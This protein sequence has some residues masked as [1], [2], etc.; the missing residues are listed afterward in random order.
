[1]IFAA[2]INYLN[3]MPGL[4]KVTE[5]YS[6]C[7]CRYMPETILQFHIYIEAELELR[8]NFLVSTFLFFFTI[9]DYIIQRFGS[10]E[11]LLFQ[12]SKMPVVPYN[13][14]QFVK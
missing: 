12:N 2:W 10:F 9:S 6:W 13:H 7:V 3:G 1:M 8:I 5:I 4:N 11:L 14:S